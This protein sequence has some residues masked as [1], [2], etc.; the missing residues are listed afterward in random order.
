MG[1]IFFVLLLIG[2]YVA[3]IVFQSTAVTTHNEAK[4][5]EQAF[6]Q[7]LHTYIQPKRQDFEIYKAKQR[8]EFQKEGISDYITDD[9][10]FISFIQS[11][12]TSGTFTSN[13]ELFYWLKEKMDETEDKISFL[14]LLKVFHVKAD[15]IIEL[16]KCREECEGKIIHLNDLD[17]QL[18]RKMFKDK[19]CALL[20]NKD[21]TELTDC[22]ESKE[23]TDKYL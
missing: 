9:D 10:I 8:S 7:I 16:L 20:R 1:I 13:A 21:F 5:V 14:F 3:Y 17:K 11:T 4:D 2:F 15:T 6:Y 22:L 23:I 19:I 18:A 12:W